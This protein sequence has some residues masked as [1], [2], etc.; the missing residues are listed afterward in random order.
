MDASWLY[1]FMPIAGV[2][3]FWPGLVLIGFSV[4]VIGG[5]FGMGGAWMVT[6]GLNIL[7][8]PMAFAIG[9]DIAHIAG[10]SMISTIRH[11]KFG[12]V[13]YKLGVVML[14]GT[15][16]GI[17]LGAQLIMWLERLG[18]VGNVVRWV[19]VGFLAL[20]ALMVFSDYAKARQKKAMGLVD[21]DKGTEG[22]TW[23]KT[24]HKIKIPPMMHF[25]AAGIYCSAWLPISVS[26]ITGI[27]AGFLGIGG[28]LLR[29]P[30][31]IYFIGAPTHIAVGTDL[32]E[33]MISGLYGAFTYTLKG[34][35][36]LV[37]VFVMLTGAAIG[38][39]IG[40]VATKYAK[41]Y[42][43][44]IAFGVAV[45]CCMVSIILKQFKYETPAAV[46]I[47]G[48][49]GVICLYIMGIMFK[50]AAQELR[51]KKAREQAL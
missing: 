12:N 10:K 41:G 33:V 15:M 29:M 31:L 8:F 49:I 22:F 50:G 24:L 5:F 30:A 51:D 11:S 39:Q 27:L 6:P 14:V 19:Y 40:T 13:D 25:K 44:R 2:N 47:L 45:L 48:T 46:L 16:A 7:G 28:G 36:E 35:I 38:A 34:R 32:F 26:F 21:G 1:M 23:Y 17:E 9:T 18:M 4:G 20:I 37:A 43:I 42:G 3:I